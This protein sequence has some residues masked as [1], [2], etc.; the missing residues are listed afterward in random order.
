[1][2][3]VHAVTSLTVSDPDERYANILILLKRNRNDDAA[4]YR[5]PSSILHITYL[6][7]A[8]VLGF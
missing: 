4:G 5:R 2:I 7:S 6:A 1:M 8:P 3:Q